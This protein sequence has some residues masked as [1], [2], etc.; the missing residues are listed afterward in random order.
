MILITGA[1]SGI[2]EACARRFARGGRNLILVA[3]RHDR[4]RALARELKRR[5]RVEV[6]IAPLDVRDRRA[7]ERFFSRRR[8][9]LAET[10]V[11][12]N[13][14]GGAHGLASLQDGSIDDW[15]TMIDTNVKGLLYFTR[16]LV[17]S[18]IARGSGHVVNIG[19]VAG[20]WVYP[21][22]NVY[23]AA[24]FAVRAITEGLR[25]DLSGT[26]LRVTEID[27]GMVE[28]EFSLVR[29][30]DS[31]KAKAVYAGMTP[32]T[33]EDVAEAVWWAVSRPRHVNIQELVLYP[34]DQASPTVVARKAKP[35]SGANSL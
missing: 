25:M 24:K 9:A 31:A 10:R 6:E 32:L 12:V 4:L 1:S 29:L 23:C 14:A 28:T 2:G 17:P 7:V 30:K 26:G 34:T 33:G 35:A 18:M 22:G 13:N 27:P 20:R 8:R 3:R 16:L 15:E 19:S 21:K 11:L 5:H